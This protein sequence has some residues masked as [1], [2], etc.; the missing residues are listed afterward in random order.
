MAKLSALER[1]KLPDAAFAYVNSKG[2][3]LLPIHDESHVRN[4][5]SRFGQVRFESDS[6]RDQSRRRL[7]KAAKR[8]GIVPVGFIEGELRKAQ[9][10]AAP[11]RLIIELGRIETSAE[12]QTELRRTLGDPQLAILHWS[13]GEG[14]YLGCDGEPVKLP[15]SKSELESTFLQGSGR[16]L[17]AILHNRDVLQTPEITEAVVAAVHLVAGKELLDEIDEIGVA[18]E[19]LPEGDVT[20]LLTDIEGSTPL[21]ES[22][23]RRYAK[24]LRDVRSVIR[25]AVLQA[26][27]RQVEARADEYVAVFG[28]ADSAVAA[29]VEMQRGM[30]A[31]KWPAASKVSIRVGLH[32]GEITL[33]EAGYIGMTVHTAARIMSAAHGG[34]I[35]VSNET[36]K[37]LGS[38]SEIELLDLGM[39][40]LRG[41]TQRHKLLQVRA[42]GLDTKFDPPSV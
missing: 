3:R 2:K 20:F 17:M 27:G 19:G 14:T 9:T 31:S 32:S 37:R 42:D 10:K 22:L 39:F 8:H 11:G 13:K 29:A 21:L 16:P 15:G 24:V 30:A 12:L 26:G 36:R 25:T 23:G 41:M 35:L 33:T 5:L 40:K 4:A 34:Q 1:K 7:L 28:D 18:T 6:A 38:G